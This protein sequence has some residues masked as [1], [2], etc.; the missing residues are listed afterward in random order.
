M[1]SIPAFVLANNG[2]D[3][4]YRFTFSEVEIARWLYENGPP[5]S[6]LIEGSRSYPSQFMNYENFAYLPI[7][8]ESLETQQELLADP[9]GVLSRWLEQSEN[10]GFV[11]LTQS[12][13]ASVYDTGIMPLGAFDTIIA[14]LLASP[15]FTLLKAA[16][17]AKV[18]GLHPRSDMFD[19]WSNT[20][21]R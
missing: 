13:M 10:G 6:L 15:R 2:K 12:Q 17:E 16:P 7:S 3:R 8:E 21:L 1:V 5:G 14:S 9:A 19:N 11:I 18:F 20:D 4:Q